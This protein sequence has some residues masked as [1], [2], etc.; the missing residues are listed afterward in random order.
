MVDRTLYSIFK[1]GSKTYFYSSLFFPM[2]VRS[3]VFILY[4]FVRKVDN[5]VDIIPQRKTEFYVFWKDFEAALKG[6]TSR[7]IVIE[8]FVSLMNQKKFDRKWVRAFFEAMEMDLIKQKYKNIEET[9]KYMYGSAEVVGLMMAS[10]MELPEESFECAR[11]LGRAMQYI[12]FIRDI[13]EDLALGREYLPQNDLQKCKLES[14]EYEYVKNHEARFNRFIRSQIKQYEEW[15]AAA[16][17]GFTYIPKRYFIP[18]KT[19]SDM[20]KWTA[21]QIKKSPIIVYE[22]KVKPSIPFIVSRFVYSTMRY[23]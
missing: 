14:L 7:D 22:K 9:K 12:N 2:D 11:H 16:E 15:Q 18:I 10:I 20:Y 1:E 4:A 3:D 23:H 6:G 5:Y 13:S 19:A 21:E 17:T 8:S